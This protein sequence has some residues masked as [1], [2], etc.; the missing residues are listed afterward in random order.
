MRHERIRILLVEDNPGDAR[1]VREFLNEDGGDFT[2]HHV[3]TVGA[4]LECLLSP[5]GSFDAV[6]LDLSLPDETPSSS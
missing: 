1:L 6:L 5:T 2:L 4:A 3:P